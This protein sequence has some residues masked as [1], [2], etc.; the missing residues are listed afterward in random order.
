MVQIGFEFIELLVTSPPSAVVGVMRDCPLKAHVKSVF[1]NWLVPTPLPCDVSGVFVYM[2]G[3]YLADHDNHT[4]WA[5]A[6]IVESDGGHLGGS[7]AHPHPPTPTQVVSC[8]V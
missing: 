7:L 2:D 4:T 3:G 6:F 1:D 8:T 5:T